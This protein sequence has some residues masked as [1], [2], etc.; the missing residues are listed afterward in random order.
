MT[1][2]VASLAARGANKDEIEHA[3]IADGMKTLWADGLEKVVAGMTTV[4][5]LARVVS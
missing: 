4:E 5:E 1:E 2:A 3:A